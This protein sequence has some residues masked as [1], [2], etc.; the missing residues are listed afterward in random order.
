MNV[1]RGASWEEGGGG[2]I[3][4]ARNNK[5]GKVQ[6]ENCTEVHTL[7]PISLILRPE[8]SDLR[9]DAV[10]VRSTDRQSQSS[11]IVTASLVWESGKEREKVVF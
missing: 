3:S 2:Q 1:E 10:S 9:F 8:K 6:T 4:E 7:P 5:V 11:F